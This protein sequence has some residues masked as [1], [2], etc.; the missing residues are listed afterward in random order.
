MQSEINIRLSGKPI[1]DIYKQ[2]KYTGLYF[3]PLDVFTANNQMLFKIGRSNDIIKRI[4]KESKETTCTCNP[5]N[6]TN[7][8]CIITDNNNE[9]E[10]ET[11][12]KQHLK[13]KQ[14]NNKE[15][16]KQISFQE[17]QS[18]L[19]LNFSNCSIISFLHLKQDIWHQINLGMHQNAYIKKGPY[20][21]KPL[22]GKFVA[23]RNG[24]LHRIEQVNNLSIK[25]K[26]SIKII[27]NKNNKLIM[28]KIKFLRKKQNSTHEVNYTLQ[29]MKWDIDNKYLTISYNSF[30]DQ[31]LDLILRTIQYHKKITVHETLL[32]WRRIGTM[33]WISKNLENT[34]DILTHQFCLMNI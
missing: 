27:P 30:E 31:L 34:S 10:M 15:I 22:N 20:T 24:E 5:Y 7:T 16:Y 2:T 21:P 11:Y 17:I 25:I 4:L 29:H 19:Q 23:N 8:M 33:Q 9:V 1:N 13:Y 12:I 14:Y 6:S 32:H 26:N 28:P 3:Y 18:I